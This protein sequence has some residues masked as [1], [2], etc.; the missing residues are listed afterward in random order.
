[1][2]A[3]MYACMCVCMH[4]CAIGARAWK[5]RSLPAAARGV[6]H[7]PAVHDILAQDP[8]HCK[9]SALSKE[10][11]FPDDVFLIFSLSLRK[12]GG[13]VRPVRRCG[14]VQPWHKEV[15]QNRDFLRHASCSA[16]Q[17]IIQP[18]ILTSS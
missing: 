4:A 5:S 3:C 8:P 10:S 14:I 2:Y 17:Y 12:S 18:F 1:M 16:N 15:G 13:T 9:I 7:S 11:P 6:I